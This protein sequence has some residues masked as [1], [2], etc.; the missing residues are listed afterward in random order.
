MS[1]TG[2]W[3]II[4]AVLAVILFGAGAW[5]FASGGS[6]EPWNRAGNPTKF[7]DECFVDL[8]KR[9][10]LDAGNTA[11]QL[12]SACKCFADGF[13]PL[14]QGK[15]QE[16]AAAYSKQSEALEKVRALR[17]KCAYQVGLDGID[18]WWN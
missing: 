8:S 11:A 13:Y 5:L 1:R 12:K 4:G 2:I 10:A 16:E 6:K 15:S 9:G 3:A 18:K 7:V 17:K 14:L